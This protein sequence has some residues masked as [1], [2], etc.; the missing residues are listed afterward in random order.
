M[1]WNTKDAEDML[2]N[3]L[4]AYA[5]LDTEVGYVQGM[6]YVSAMLLMHIQDEEKVFWCL[7]HLL[8]RQ[9]YRSIYMEEMPK[10]MDLIEIIEK[11]MK[12]EYA[13]IYKHLYE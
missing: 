11:K 13:H 2:F 9:N 5:N 10:L 3:I 4:I 6:N 7:T 8:H 1:S 12:K